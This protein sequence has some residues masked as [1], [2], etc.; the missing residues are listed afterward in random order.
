MFNSIAQTVDLSVEISDTEKKAAYKAII[1][2]EKLEKRLSSFNK[3][4]NTMYHPFK[5]YNA[6]S[7]ESILKY[8]GAIWKYANK[9]RDDFEE[10]REIAGECVEYL[11]VF[12]TDSHINDIINTFDDSIGEID[13]RVSI[14]FTAISN[15]SGPSYKDNVLKALE[16]LKKDVAEL[17]KLIYDRIIEHINNNIIDKNWI[18]SISDNIKKDLKEKGP[19]ISK[20]HKKRNNR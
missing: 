15:W 12:D 18:D 4:L 3:Y 1:K 2:L 13:D 17:R 20:L 6:I 10:L 8:R 14:A 9:I 16:S 5:K 11:K 19:H 7:D